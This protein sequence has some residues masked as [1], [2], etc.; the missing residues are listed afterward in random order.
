M[1]KSFNATTPR[2]ISEKI[3]DYCKE[4]T[5][6][7]ASYHAVTPD[8]SSIVGLCFHNVE[9]HI[10][11]FGGEVQ[12]G[13]AIWEFPNIFLTAEFHAVVNQDGKFIDVTPQSLGEK[14]ILF[15]PSDSPKPTAFTEN[16]FLPLVNHPMIEKFIQCQ[17]GKQKLCADG[18]QGGVK[19]DSLDRE[20]V[21]CMQKY[22]AELNRRTKTKDLRSKRKAERRRKKRK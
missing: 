19:H 8:S 1:K 11:Q 16:E 13:W 4:L 5:G 3:A 9:D 15:T 6:N 14:R 7:E 21:S 18:S 2:R 17:K 20:A 12:Y 22:H 10:N